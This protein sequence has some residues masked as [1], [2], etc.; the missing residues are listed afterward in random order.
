MSEERKW[1]REGSVVNR[2]DRVLALEVDWSEEGGV[3]L[4]G[5]KME[6]GMRRQ[7]RRGEWV[8]V[9]EQWRRRVWVNR[10]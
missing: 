7:T 10:G 3:Q 8:N 5:G 6:R 4:C 1:V 9:S 2:V